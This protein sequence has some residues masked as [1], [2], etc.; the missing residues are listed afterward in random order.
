VYAI[1][2]LPA[3]QATPEEI[4]TWAKEHW[5]VENTV[6]WSRDVTFHEDHCQVR[7]ANAPAVLAAIRDLVRGA[8]HLAGY[9]NTAT[10]RRGHIQPDQALA[11]YRIE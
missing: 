4:A 3:E 8:L 2:D 5:T 1:T 6:H 11:L 7:T 9:A 10:G